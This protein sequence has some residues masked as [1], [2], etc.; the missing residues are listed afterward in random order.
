M[1]VKVAWRLHANNNEKIAQA[2]LLD[3]HSFDAPPRTARNSTKFH[4]AKEG[5]VDS[6][7]RAS[8]TFFQYFLERRDGSDADAGIITDAA[9]NYL[10][11]TETEDV[12]SAIS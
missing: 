6:R 7:D 11:E 9:S 8:H 12:L 3:Y 4:R 10:R 5:F 1:N 2:M